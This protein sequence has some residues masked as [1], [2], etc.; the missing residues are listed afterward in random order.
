MSTMTKTD[1]NVK[2]PVKRNNKKYPFA[3]LK[4]KKFKQNKHT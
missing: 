2:K 4:I 3:L 1:S